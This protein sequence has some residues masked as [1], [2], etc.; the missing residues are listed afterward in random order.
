[1]SI[2]TLDCTVVLLLVLVETLMSRDDLLRV[3]R[4]VP[5]ITSSTK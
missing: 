3:L 5:R 2:R 1:M 4:P